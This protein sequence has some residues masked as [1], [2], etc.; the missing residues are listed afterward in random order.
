MEQN[1]T[2]QDAVKCADALE[3]RAEDAGIISATLPALRE[4]AIALAAKPA[5]RSEIA[6]RAAVRP[7]LALLLVVLGLHPDAAAF[8]SNQA[9]TF[10]TGVRALWGKWMQD[11]SSAATLAVAMGWLK[12]EGLQTPRAQLLTDLTRHMAGKEKLDRI[13]MADKAVLMANKDVLAAIEAVRAG[14]IGKA[15]DHNIQ[16]LLANVA[17]LGAL[18]TPATPPEASLPT[19]QDETVSA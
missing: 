15:L 13:T 19:D 11:R 3:R 7:A 1:T 17:T 8:T 12:S 2:Q 10:Y 14:H 4:S 9:D 5:P 16:T 18:M 6:K